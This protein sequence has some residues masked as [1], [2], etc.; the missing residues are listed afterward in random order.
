MHSLVRRLGVVL[1]VSLTAC[2]NDQTVAPSSSADGPLAGPAYAILPSPP[3][4]SSTSVF[5]G[6][7]IQLASTLSAKRNHAI[8]WSTPFNLNVY[9]AEFTL[10][11]V[12]TKN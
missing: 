11:S 1:T 9:V 7:S 12:D 5:V 4:G 3:E 6:D 8:S 2:Q 10:A